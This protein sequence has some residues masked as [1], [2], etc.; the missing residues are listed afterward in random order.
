[1]TSY[2]CVCVCVCMCVRVSLVVC[3]IIN[4]S[5]LIMQCVALRTHL[6]RPVSHALG[7]QIMCVEG[8]GNVR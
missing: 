1:M 8:E 6:V 2:L 5:T 3:F 7:A 4:C